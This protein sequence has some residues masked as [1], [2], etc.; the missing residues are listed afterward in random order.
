MATNTPQVATNVFTNEFVSSRLGID[1]TTRIELGTLGSVQLLHTMPY[2]EDKYDGMTN[3]DREVV[4]SGR[5]SYAAGRRYRKNDARLLRHF[6]MHDHT[7]PLE[8]VRFKF[9]IVAP[10][11]VRT[12][13]IR[14]RTGSINEF[15]QRF[16]QAPESFYV[17]IQLRGQSK[18]NKQGSVEADLPRSLIDDLHESYRASYKSYRHLLDAGVTREQAR[19][20]LPQGTQTEFVWCMDLHNLLRFLYLRDSPEAQWETQQFAKAISQLVEPLLPITFAVWREKKN[21]YARMKDEIASLRE[22]LRLLKEN[23]FTAGQSTMD[24]SA[25]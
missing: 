5:A 18:T 12:H 23:G 7:S 24:T 14:H 19:F 13:I 8:M 25:I 22:E 2:P 9:H 21:E 10:L 16:K 6:I 20:L 3:L 17:P 15:S 1:Y 11:A 4:Y